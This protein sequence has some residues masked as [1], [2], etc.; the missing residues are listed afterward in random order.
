MSLTWRPIPVQQEQSFETINN[1]LKDGVTF[2]NGGEFYGPPTD[3]TANL[4]L[5]HNYLEEFPENRSKM[6]IA[7]KGSV[8]PDLTPDNS[9]E[10][11]AKSVNHICSFFPDD[12]K[13]IFEP[14]RM[15]LTHS[16]EQVMQYLAPF[17][18]SGK[19]AG[20]SLSEVNGDSIRQASKVHPISYV[21]VEFSMMTR[22]IFENGVND[23]CRELG[24]PIVAY[25]P[26]GR[27][28]LTGNIRKLEDI[29]KGD[30]RLMLDR[31][32]NDENI[33]NNLAIADVVVELAQKKKCTPAQLALNWIRKHSDFPEKYATI[34]PIPS[35][36]T[37]ERN[38]ENNA[39]VPL[40][41]EEFDEINEKIS[42]ITIH[43]L[44]YNEHADKY[45]SL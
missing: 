35:S 9:A 30:M 25:S 2:F 14:A 3:Q 4:K 29:P 28:F 21:E 36:S 26:I 42:K 12:V 20:I 32:N 41:D 44:R 1:A 11:L 39:L 33:K 16:P 18:K 40:T 5:L 15:D 7:I 31:F 37:P 23:A 13:I 22:E 45:L 8:G 27:G 24:I 34:I 17:V 6:T 38:H 10:N 43:G 19:L